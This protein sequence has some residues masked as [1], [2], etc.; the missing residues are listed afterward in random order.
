MAVWLTA[1]V[2]TRES[3]AVAAYELGGMLR[4]LRDSLGL[5][6]AE[7]ARAAR[8]TPQYLS[9]VENGRK[10]PA[11]EKLGAILDRLEVGPEDR[12]ELSALRTV[13]VRRWPLS[14]HSGM[15]G[16]EF[17]RFCGFEQGC[18]TMQ[19]WSPDVVH[20]LLQ[21]PDYAAGVIRSG[22][23]RI[24]QTEVE[25]R[26]QA[27]LLRQR[28]LDG[29]DGVR[30]SVILGEAAVRQHVGGPAAL[31]GQLDHL[32]SAQEERGDRLELRVLPFAGSGH[33]LLGVPMFHLLGF[34]RTR[35]GPQVWTE[36]IPSMHLFDDARAVHDFRSTYAEAWDVALGP[37]ESRR[38]IERVR[39]ELL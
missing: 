20:G 38:L 5:P 15:F 1:V 13:A 21:T 27:R 10:V 7:V 18:E 31:V 8:C 39:K 16:S 25:R 3:P 17:L 22:G 30:L 28:C 19:S 2:S 29:D 37:L 14:A 6:A 36:D 9:Q 32:L 23:V 26:V 24:R 11:V 33:P 34:A 4:D 12:E 35:V